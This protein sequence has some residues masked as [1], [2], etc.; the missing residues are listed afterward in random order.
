MPTTIQRSEYYTDGGHYAV[1]TRTTALKEAKLAR[2]ADHLCRNARQLVASTNPPHID[3][4][5]IAGMMLR[6]A[7]NLAPMRIGTRFDY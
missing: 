1:M 4:C 2:I 5:R 7:H 6:W 3:N